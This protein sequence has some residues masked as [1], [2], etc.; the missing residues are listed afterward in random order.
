MRTGHRAGVFNEPFAVSPIET[1]KFPRNFQ[2]ISQKFLRNF[3][4]IYQKFLKNFSETSEIF[5]KY[6]GTFRIS[7]SDRIPVATYYLTG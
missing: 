6:S 7:N 3:S 1:A 5:G 2:E 4:E